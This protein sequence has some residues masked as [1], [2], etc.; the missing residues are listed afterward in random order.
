MLG[1]TSADGCA[2]VY[3]LEKNRLAAVIDFLKF[4]TEKIYW[5]FGVLRDLSVKKLL[6]CCCCMDGSGDSCGMN[7]C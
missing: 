3:L 7:R 1:S 4:D 6:G 2:F 5:K